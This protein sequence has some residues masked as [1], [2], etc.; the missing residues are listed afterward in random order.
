MRLIKQIFAAV[1]LVGFVSTASAAQFNRADEKLWEPI[2]ESF[3]SDR[4]MTDVDFIKIEA[5]KRAESGA[6]VPVT[7]SID[8]KAANGVIIEK[9]YSFVDGNP[10]PLTATFHLSPTLGDF[11]LATRIRFEKDAYVRLV[12]EDAKGNL[13]LASRVIRAAGGCGGVVA[14]DE[15]KVRAQA[16]KIKMKVIGKPEAGKVAKA[17]F[18]IR[19]VMRTGL[20]RDLVSQG[21][22]PAFYINKTEFTYND[23]PLMTV[24]VNVGTAEN[25]YFK[26]DFMPKGPGKLKVV[27]VDNEGKQFNKVI[28]I[29]S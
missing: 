14:N 3:F 29:K 9:L 26:F 4:K 13:Y 7:Y 2:K 11:K 27:A 16:G 1:V 19:H 21:F 8:S 25:P 12:G 20:Q 15:A 18:N 23:K 10:I 6:Q 17:V 28:D 22:L 5:P 24:D